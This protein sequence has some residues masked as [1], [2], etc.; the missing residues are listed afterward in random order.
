MAEGGLM[1]V[2][3]YFIAAVLPAVILLIYIYRK[4]R[5]EKEPGKLLITLLFGGLLAAAAS[6]ALETGAEW[7][8]EYLLGYIHLDEQGMALLDAFE[9]ALIEEG[10]KYWLLKRITWKSKAFNYRFDGVVYAV[11]VSLGFAAIENILYIF[12]YAGLD[13]ALMRALLAV[14]AHMTFA[15]YMGVCYGRAKMYDRRGSRGL[16]EMFLML[17]YIVPVV[18]HTVYDGTLMIGSD[19]AMLVFF[20]FVIL[21][22]IFV[23]IR[24][25]FD[26]GKDVYIG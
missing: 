14:P 10:T 19:E 25:R 13:A 11:F 18:L 3:I 6:L 21:I 15:V 23:L 4:D 20:A 17:A 24:I 12:L 5:V 26:S 1:T 9:V 2:L 8:T 16:K 7:A 22:D